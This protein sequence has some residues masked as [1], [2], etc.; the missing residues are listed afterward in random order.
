MGRLRA[1]WALL[2]LLGATGC[3]GGGNRRP[4]DPLPGSLTASAS[5]PTPRARGGLFARRTRLP[6]P[7][8]T[9][10]SP[11]I[12]RYFP[13][14]ARPAAGSGPAPTSA[15]LVARPAASPVPAHRGGDAGESVDTGPMLPIALHVEVGPAG[16]DSATTRLVS[17][18]QPIDPAAGPPPLAEAEPDAEPA[19]RELAAAPADP[20]ELLEAPTAR[21]P[22]ARPREVR[23]VQEL[24]GAADPPELI[25][26]PPARG[27][28]PRPPEVRPVAYRPDPGGPAAMLPPVLF[29][30]SY[31]DPEPTTPDPASVAS[32][33]GQ[34]IP[35]AAKR[36]WRPWSARAG[37]ARGEPRDLPQGG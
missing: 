7:I 19:S 18:E 27:P 9:A 23:P 4:P 17:H 10:I 26:A 5:T 28:A 15:G 35:P 12:A 1:V 11:T 33:A 3:A 2:M 21:G 13:G 30:R 24:A 36:A 22:A 8:T 20:P 34:A 25:E 29:P 32:P 14:L 37:L 31:Y 6:R 16:P